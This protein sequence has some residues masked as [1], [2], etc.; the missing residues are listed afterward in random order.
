[1]V[2]IKPGTRQS[3]RRRFG[4]VRKLP[5]G[6]WQARYGTPD[7]RDHP[8]PGTFPTKTAADRWLAAVQTDIARGQWVD[9]RSRQLMLS[10]Y[11]DSWLPARTDLKIRTW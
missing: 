5:S 9:P 4:R 10:A 1:M 8:A 11:A 7:G 3:G 6:R 2:S